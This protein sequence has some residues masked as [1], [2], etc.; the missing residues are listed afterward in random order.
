MAKTQVIINEFDNGIIVDKYHFNYI[1]ELRFGDKYL[2]KSA[3][4][5]FSSKDIGTIEQTMVNLA[6]NAKASLLLIGIGCVVID[7]E[8]LYETLGYKSYLEY[9]KHLYEGQGMSVQTISD[10]KII[11]EVF[12][13]HFSNLNKAGF[14][15]ENNAHKLRYLKMAL[16]KYSHAKASVYKKIASST[17]MEFKEWATAS[18]EPDESYHPVIKVTSTKIMIDGTDILNFSDDLPTEERDHLSGYLEAVYKIRATGNEPFIMETYDAGEQRA[19]L[20][21]QKKFRAGR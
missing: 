3:I 18:D 1:Q 20:N 8:A 16:K 10:A 5:A 6:T 19:I 9:A 17:F 15:I 14:N 12:I 4:Q 7:R 13:D 11:A 21:F 2:G